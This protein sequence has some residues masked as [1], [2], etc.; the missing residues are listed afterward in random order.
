LLFQVGSLGGSALD[1]LSL[2]FFTAASEAVGFDLVFC[3][4]R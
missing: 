1:T 2:K 3:Y 4:F